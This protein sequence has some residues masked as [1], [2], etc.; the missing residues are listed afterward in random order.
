M[1]RIDTLACIIVVILVTQ[2]IGDS[3]QK[4]KQD[5]SKSSNVVSQIYS[6]LFS[7]FQKQHPNIIRIE[8]NDIRAFQADPMYLGMP[9]N[10]FLVLARG[11]YER[12]GHEE[13]ELF[14]IF[15]FDDSLVTI[16]RTIDI[17]D[18][19]HDYAYTIAKV[20]K[21]TLTIHGEGIG[22]DLDEVEK[23]YKLY[24]WGKYE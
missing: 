23:K 16:L 3:T 2:S 15:V 13:S 20:W 10:R 11:I 9:A 12:G 24:F 18:Y 17:I 22:K 5:Q 14:G 1:K 8:L 4:P 6:T 7:Q 19:A 21:D